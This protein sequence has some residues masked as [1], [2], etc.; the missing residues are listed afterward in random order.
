MKKISLFIAILVI[1]GAGVM[2]VNSVFATTSILSDCKILPKTPM[3]MNGTPGKCYKIPAGMTKYRLSVNCQNYF[4][5]GNLWTSSGPW[6]SV[7]EGIPSMLGGC[8]WWPA[9]T[10]SKP[11]FQFK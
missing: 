5:I 6:I 11:Y 1:V 3:L 8:G 9:M 7:K 4:T 2:S 10:I